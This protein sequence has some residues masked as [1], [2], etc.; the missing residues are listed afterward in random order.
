[1]L[2]QWWQSHYRIMEI[3]DRH[4]HQTFLPDIPKPK[5]TGTFWLLLPTGMRTLPKKHYIWIPGVCAITHL[6]NMVN[7]LRS[8]RGIYRPSVNYPLYP[9]N[10]AENKQRMML[11]H[12]SLLKQNQ[13]CRKLRVGHLSEAHL[14]HIHTLNFVNKTMHTQNSKTH[15]WTQEAAAISWIFPMSEL[16]P[17]LIILIVTHISIKYRTMSALD[18]RYIVVGLTL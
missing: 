10:D 16:A 11:I 12:K 13:N 18:A 7:L 1:M 15:S 6:Q 9:G 5:L 3:A 2:T 17:T 14:F 4:V 8:E